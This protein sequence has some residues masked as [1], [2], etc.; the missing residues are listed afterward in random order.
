MSPCI[1]YTH[2]SSHLKDTFLHYLL[3]EL[4]SRRRQGKEPKGL[5]PLPGHERVCLN[6]YFPSLSPPYCVEFPFQKVFLS[7]VWW[8]S[9][10]SCFSVWILLPKRDEVGRLLFPLV[11]VVLWFGCARFDL[12]GP[13]RLF[14]RVGFGPTIS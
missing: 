3:T 12:P 4:D 7:L 9:S 14:C 6:S 2:I 13:L 8:L 11:A 10:S 1:N 5:L